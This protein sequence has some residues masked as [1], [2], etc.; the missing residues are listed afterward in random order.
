[1]DRTQPKPP[2]LVKKQSSK[3]WLE[4]HGE[5]KKRIPLSRERPKPIPLIIVLKP[6]INRVKALC[7]SQDHLYFL[8]AF[9]LSITKV[10]KCFGGYKK[11]FHSFNVMLL[12]LYSKTIIMKEMESIENRGS[13]PTTPLVELLWSNDMDTALTRC[14]LAKWHNSI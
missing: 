9:I 11:D 8:S 7:Q 4:K 6:V 3:K 12:Y 10:C 14:N 5:N 1:M 13:K 2:M